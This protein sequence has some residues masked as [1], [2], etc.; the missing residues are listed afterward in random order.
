MK[1]FA[2][3]TFS[4]WARC[5][6]AVAVA[7]VLSA[8]GTASVSKDVDDAG[9][10]G[11]VVFPKLEDAWVKEGSFPNAE[12]LR[13]IGPGVT[14]DQLYLL[15]GRPH[16]K[17]GMGS[18]R[19]WDYIFKFRNG[20][21]EPTVCQYKVV[22][23]KVVH[24]QTFHWLPASC[25]DLIKERPVE[26]V[27]PMAARAPAPNAVVHKQMQ[28]SGDA[29]FAFGKSGIGDL[30]HG[31]QAQLDKVLASLGGASNVE[32]LEVV[33]HSDRIGSEAANQVLS[34]ARARSVADYFASKGVARDKLV[35][36]GRGESEPIVQCTNG[37]KSAL[38][39]C[40][41]P[42]RR[43]VLNALSRAGF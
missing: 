21:A 5:G 6:A 29:L 2:M 25:A 24:G 36:A 38:V 17:E 19:E 42:N 13:K 16:F 39:G 7:A 33:G 27:V 12:N 43:V 26:A 1:E 9:V 37:T 30:L 3:F 18:V 40:L 10:A 35:V 23:D 34:L 22:F 28:L 15:A 11:E 20:K 41:A 4:D 32:R 14:K 8:C 31:G